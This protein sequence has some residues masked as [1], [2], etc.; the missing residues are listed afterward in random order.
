MG[1]K[2]FETL[3]KP[4][5]NRLNIVLSRSMNQDQSQGVRIACSIKDAIQIGEDSGLEGPIWIAG[6]GDIYQQSMGLVDLIVCTR[7]HAQVRGDT[8]FPEIDPKIW[9]RAYFEDFPANDR[10]SHAFTVEWWAKISD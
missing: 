9:G 7:V 5:P 3:K 6:G 2:T 4:L 8:Y 10:Q 1:R